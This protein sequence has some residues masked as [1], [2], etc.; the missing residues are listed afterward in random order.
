MIHEA[1]LAGAVGGLLWL[2]RFQLFQVQISRPLVSAPLVGWILGDLSAGLA[3]GLLFELLWLRR[4]PV[5][6]YIPPDSTLASIATAAVSAMVRAHTGLPLTATVF[7]SFLFMLPVAHLGKKLD[8]FLR[9]G[10]G[11][12]ARRAEE[13]LHRGSER[14]IYIYGLTALALGFC[15]ALAALFPVIILGTVITQE[16]ARLIPPLYIKA[17]AYGFYVVPLVGV[18]DM[19]AGPQYA[20]YILLFIL[21]FA[22]FLGGSVL[23]NW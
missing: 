4:P 16:L 15:C 8:S 1:L 9:V 10:L 20:R 11:T 19:M 12:L 2:D 14:G 6:G 3:S 23:L 7:L 5:G 22:A 21:G 18:A 13:V 17:C